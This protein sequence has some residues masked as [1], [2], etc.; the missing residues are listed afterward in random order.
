MA[1]KGYFKEGHK[2]NQKYDYTVVIDDLEKYIDERDCPIVVEFCYLNNIPKSSLYEMNSEAIKNL[3]KKATAKK[4][5]Y[6]ESKCLNNEINSAMAI[7]SLKQLGWRDKQEIVSTNMNTN[8]ELDYSSL[9]NKD[10]NMIIEIETKL[11]KQNES[12]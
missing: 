12:N 1:N 2:I 9:S 7:F 5:F 3:I 8:V 11:L 10:L 4:E 6:L